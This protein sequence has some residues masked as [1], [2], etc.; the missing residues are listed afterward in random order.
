[1]T[2]PPILHL[3]RNIVLVG[4]MGSGKSTVGRALA[5]RLRWPLIDT[6]HS[7]VQEAGG[8]SIAS[9]FLEEGESGFRDRE[10]DAVQSVCARSGQVIATGGG[11]AVRSENVFALRSAGVIVWLTARPDVVVARTRRAART[12]PMLGSFP[13]DEPVEDNVILERVL[14]LLAERAPHYQAASDI[15]VD[16]SDRPPVAIAAEIHRKA[17][18]WEPHQREAPRR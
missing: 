11:T 7:I 15:V 9:V 17:E 1:M 18:R 3:P 12:R 6:D 10:S 4:F 5:E 8:R 14:S 16:T 2:R 13:G